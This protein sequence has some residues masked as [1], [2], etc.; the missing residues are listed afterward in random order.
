MEFR[1]SLF[2]CSWLFTGGLW[3]FASGFRSF[4]GGL[5][6]PVVVCVHLLV[7]CGRLWSFAGGLCSFVV[8]CG[9][10]PVLVPTF[11]NNVGK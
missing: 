2:G 10:L 9:G 4:A 1:K 8:V 5:G 11:E 3:S 7:V 6:S